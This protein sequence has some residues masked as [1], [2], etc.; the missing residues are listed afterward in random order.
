MLLPKKTSGDIRGREGGSQ[1]LGLT[2]LDL[3]QEGSHRKAEREGQNV[4]GALKALSSWD[5]RVA[6]R[7]EKV[8]SEGAQN[9][10]SIPL[11]TT[12]YKEMTKHVAKGLCTLVGILVPFIRVEN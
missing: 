1:D 12:N 11:F 2:S 5:N 4:G 7:G 6:E 9:H 3:W 10:M 8:C